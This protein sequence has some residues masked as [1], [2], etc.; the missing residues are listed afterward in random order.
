MFIILSTFYSDSSFAILSSK[1]LIWLSV[2]FTVE[3]RFLSQ[4][5]PNISFWPNVDLAI[6]FNFGKLGSLAFWISIARFKFLICSCLFVIITSS[7]FY[8]NV[9]HQILLIKVVLINLFPNHAK[10]INVLINIGKYMF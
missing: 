7:N 10:I 8:K 2:A 6:I 9:N 5:F 1:F 3:L 4:S